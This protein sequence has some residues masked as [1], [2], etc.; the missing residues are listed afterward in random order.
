MPR[1][2]IIGSGSVT[3]VLAANVARWVSALQSAERQQGTPVTSAAAMVVRAIGTAHLPASLA[4]TR[5]AFDQAV[6][7]LQRGAMISGRGA[8]LTAAIQTLRQAQEGLTTM[9]S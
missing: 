9:G 4:P 7:Q 3:A 5:R 2:K 8:D 6:N 1:Q